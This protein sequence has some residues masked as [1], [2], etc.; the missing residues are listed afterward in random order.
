MYHVKQW[1]NLFSYIFFT[2]FRDIFA[3]IQFS[4]QVLSDSV[5]RVMTV[6][7][8]DEMSETAK[9]ILLM[10]RFF[11]C[12]NVRSETEGNRTRKPDRLPFVT[13]DD[14]RLKVVCI[15]L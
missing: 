8:S 4:L 5:G 15:L 7:G 10:D 12:L 13:L 14:P 9:F 2:Y 3:D 11:D 1:N 6:Y